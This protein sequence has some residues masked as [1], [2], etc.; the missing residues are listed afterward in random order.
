MT[1][2]TIEQYL[3]FVATRVAAAA[4][5][6]D[7]KEIVRLLTLCAETCLDKAIELD[8]DEELQE[9]GG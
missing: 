8:N 9:D 5:L 4:V 2:G 6:G 1:T 7:W 3:N